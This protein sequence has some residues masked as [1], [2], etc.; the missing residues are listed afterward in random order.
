MRTMK[1]KRDFY[2]GRLIGAKD[3]RFMLNRDVLD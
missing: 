1:I 3:D 2:L